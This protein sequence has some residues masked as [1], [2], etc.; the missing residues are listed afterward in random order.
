[1][2]PSFQ[3]A[4]PGTLNWETHHHRDPRLKEY[5]GLIF[6]SNDTGFAGWN[7]GMKEAIQFFSFSL[8]LGF[9]W[10]II[11]IINIYLIYTVN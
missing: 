5:S 3:A 2:I 6:H 1:M 7:E 4:Y 9:F 11:A 10:K 8:A